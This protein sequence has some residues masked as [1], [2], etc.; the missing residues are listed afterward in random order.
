[1]PRFIKYLLRVFV[2]FLLISCNYYFCAN[3][4]ASNLPPITSNFGWRIDPISSEWRFH[5]GVDF[6]L[7]YGAAVNVLFDGIVV[8]AGNHG[9][10]YGNQI[11][12]YHPV[13]DAYTRYAHCSVIYVSI[14]QEVAAGDLIGLVG[15]TGRSTGPH[16]HLEYIIN[17]DNGYQYTNP[18][19]L[20][21]GE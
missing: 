1:M 20:W 18:L 3:G 17:T 14:D 2:I 5:A 13:I 8:D 21:E 9:D 7:E 12:I 16:L 11:L 6:G 10:G 15:S 19:V 4:S